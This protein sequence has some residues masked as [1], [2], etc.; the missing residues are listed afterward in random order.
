[1]VGAGH[2]TTVLTSD[3]CRNWS[4]VV[5][6]K[7]GPGGGA[8]A[9][10]NS[11]KKARSSAKKGEVRGSEEKLHKIRRKLQKRPK[12]SRQLV[13]A[14]PV[15]RVRDCSRKKSVP[16]RWGGRVEADTNIAEVFQTDYWK[17]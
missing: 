6:A 10:S 9:R 15:S 1:M 16:R 13:F 14:A 2:V 4:H 3:W 12:S 17:T 11:A 8:G 7:A 5:D